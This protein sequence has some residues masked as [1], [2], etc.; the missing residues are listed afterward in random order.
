VL[1]ASSTA[2]GTVT[3]GLETVAVCFRA[4]TL[5]ERWWRW[6]LLLREAE[7][8]RDELADA[9]GLMPPPNAVP[10]ELALEE[11]PPPIC[12]A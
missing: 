2:A 11:E 12:R 3:A 9:G 6:A 5:D 10:V 8:D 1:D 4:P 7:P